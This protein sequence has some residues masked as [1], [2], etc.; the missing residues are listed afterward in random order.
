[1]SWSSDSLPAPFDVVLS[2]FR[3]AAQ[4]APKDM[5]RLV[6][7]NI[8]RGY[9]LPG[10]VD[11]LRRLDA[12]VIAL[13]EVDI[14]CERSGFA[15]CSQAI[16]SALGLSCAFV[17]EFAEL[18]SPLRSAATQGGGVHGQALLSRYALRDCRAL[19]H[20]CQPVDWAAEGEARRE[21]RLGCVIAALAGVQRASDSQPAAAAAWR[22]SPPWRALWA[23]CLCTIYTWKCFAASASGLPSFAT[24]WRTAGC[25]AGPACKP[26]WAT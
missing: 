17:A 19:V 20:S 8:E 7:W 18:H 3:P 1:M 15:D 5:L 23:R 10:I 9:Q 14:G 11:E 4:P 24:C 16:A 13:Q 26:F 2:D 22:S 21:P 12:D 25:P 6:T